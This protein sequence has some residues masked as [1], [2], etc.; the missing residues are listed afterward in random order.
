MVS[1][2]YDRQGFELI[3]K[4]VNGNKEYKFVVND[5]YVKK[6]KIIFVN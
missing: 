2:F 1:D 5:N 4:D 6:N 3:N